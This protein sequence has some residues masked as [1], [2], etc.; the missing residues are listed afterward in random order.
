MASIGKQRGQYVL[1]AGTEP[2]EVSCDALQ[3]ID[4]PN[5]SCMSVLYLFK[6]YFCLSCLVTELTFACSLLE[7]QYSRDKCWLERRGCF[8]QEVATWEEGGLV[9]KNH[10]LGIPWWSSREDSMLLLQGTWV[11]SLVGELR[12]CKHSQN[13]QLLRFC[14]TMNVF[15]GRIIW[16]G[17]KSLHYLPLCADFL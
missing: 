11:R 10:L 16:G 3:R 2:L 8:I 17:D 1:K 7:S 13:K 6:P 14:S 5:S 15:K 12:S 4:F 9:S